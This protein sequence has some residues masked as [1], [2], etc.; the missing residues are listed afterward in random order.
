MKSLLR[1]GLSIALALLIAAPLISQNYNLALRSTMTFAS[2]TTLANIC[3]Y[4]QNGREYALLGGSLGMIIVDITNPD[5]PVQIVQIP[6]PNNEWKE[7]K[8]YKTFAYVTSE[9]GQGVQV[10]NLSNLPSPTLEYHYYKGTGAITGQLNAI[11]ALHIDVTKGFLYTYGGGFEGAV[12]HNLEPDPY[13]PQYVGQYQELGYVHDGYA[14]NDTL[15]AAHIYTG[16]MAIVDMADKSAPQILGTVITPNAFTHNVWLTSDHKTALTTDETSASFLTAYDVSDPSDIKE[17]DRI[18]PTPGSGSIVH[19]THIINDFAVTSWYRDGITIVDAHRPQNLIQVGW[20]DTWQGGGDGFDGCWGVFPFFQSGAVVTSNISPPVFNVLTP[21]YVR[22]C[23]LE[24][25]ITNSC[26]GAPLANVQVKINH[27]DLLNNTISLGNGIYRTGQPTP[28]NFTATFTKAGYISKTVN[29][30]LVNGEVTAIDVALD[31]VQAY[32]FTGIVK[33]SQTLAPVANVN[34]SLSNGTESFLFTTDAAGTF[35]ASCIPQ[36]VYLLKIYQWGYLPLGAVQVNAGGSITMLVDPGYYDS[37]ESD[38]G[39]TNAA[40][41]PT[42]IWER[43]DPIGTGNNNSANPEDDVITDND[44]LC[45]VTG[46]GGG[47]QGTDDVDDGSATLNSPG[48]ALSAYADPILRYKYWFFN[49][50]GSGGPNDNMTVKVRNGITEAVLTTITQSASEWRNSGDIHLKNFIALTDN[51]QIDFIAS[52]IAPG[53]V[54]EGGVDVFEVALG[55]LLS[56][57]ELAADAFFSASP[58]PFGHSTRLTF[59]ENTRKT[60][61]VTLVNA[62]GQ[63]VFEQAFD[64]GSESS[65]ELGAELPTGVYWACLQGA[66]WKTTPVKLIKQ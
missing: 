60:G 46:N 32:S 3:G 13:N 33:N 11:H 5:A 18:Q 59:K 42:G 56:D 31:P 58:N 53:H 43:C 15:Y 38:L 36:G 34:A 63:V 62:F 30:T 24:G 45:Y 50:G 64:S 40:T 44:V 23:Y 6:G 49:G 22:A 21:T 1:N 25:V 55:T 28:G 14:D 57:S 41:S 54:V 65:M 12:V 19:N 10:V 7:I 8:V 9:G 61:Q 26:D 48:M 2:Q 35:T 52:D 39:W 17:L 37:F 16:N 29:C 27:T 47:N 4:S 20:Y 51:M 66:D